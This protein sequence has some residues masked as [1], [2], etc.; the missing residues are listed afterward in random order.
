MYD[1]SIF[2]DTQ[3]EQ[4]ETKQEL[5]FIAGMLDGHIIDFEFRGLRVAREGESVYV[6]D[7]ETDEQLGGRMLVRRA[8]VKYT[9][10]WLERKAELYDQRLKAQG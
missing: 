1:N 2:S 10:E 6:Y 9:H 5:G 4:T 8:S 3:D 7:S